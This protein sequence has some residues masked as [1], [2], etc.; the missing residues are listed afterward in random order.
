MPRFYKLAHGDRSVLGS[1]P[2][3]YYVHVCFDNG[4]RQCV[5]MGEGAGHGSVGGTLSAEEASR[6]VWT[7]HVKYAD[8]SWLQPYLERMAAGE[9]VS[10]DE[11][12]AHYTS[13][14]GKPPESY[15]TTFG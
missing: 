3:P 14:H 10:A 12:I 13:I 11:V 1:A 8:G 5:S 6:S 4:V 9:H 15:E 2:W 7:E